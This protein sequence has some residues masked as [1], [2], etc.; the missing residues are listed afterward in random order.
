MTEAVERLLQ[1]VE[2]F[3][4]AN[5]AWLWRFGGESGVLKAVGSEFE[6]QMAV[7]VEI[8]MIVCSGT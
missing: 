4:I 7:G 8:Y 3:G 2:C 6:V 1:C 5:S